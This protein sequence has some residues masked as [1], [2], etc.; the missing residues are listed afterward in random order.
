MKN[1]QSKLKS[2]GTKKMTVK[3]ALGWQDF[4]TS[5]DE[6]GERDCMD[7]QVQYI[8]DKEIRDCDTEDEVIERHDK[9][10]ELFPHPNIGNE[11]FDCMI[12]SYEIPEQINVVQLPRV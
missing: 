3:F 7:P 5:W 10:Y 9:R 11:P 6:D 2:L 12:V 1:D 4:N 8:M